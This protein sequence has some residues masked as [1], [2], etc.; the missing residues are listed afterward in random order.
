ME[1][2]AS[3]PVRFRPE[4]HDLDDWI[5]IRL[6]LDD[7]DRLEKV[8]EISRTFLDDFIENLEKNE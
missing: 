3:V 2:K 5:E 4:N 6:T 1:N 7:I 8:L